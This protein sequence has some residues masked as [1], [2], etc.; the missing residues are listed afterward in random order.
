VQVL[1][2]TWTLFRCYYSTCLDFATYDTSSRVIKVLVLVLIFNRIFISLATSRSCVP[3]KGTFTFMNI[4][5]FNAKNKNMNLQS[6]YISCI[7]TIKGNTTNNCHTRA[8]RNKVGCISYMRQE[9]NIYNNRVYR[10]KCHN[11]IRVFIT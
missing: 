11:N 6:T 5:K 2:K 9:D 1:F 8:L 7:F 4:Y 10:Y 3:P